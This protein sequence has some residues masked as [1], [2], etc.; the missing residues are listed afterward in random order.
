[1]DLAPGPARLTSLL[2]NDV[3]ARLE[4]LRIRGTRRFTNPTH[5]ETLAGRTGSSTEF[6]DYRDYVEGDDVRFI[7]W[8]AFARLR[9]PYLKLYRREEDV[10][11]AVLVDASA[12]MAFEG[13]LDLAKSLAA[14][15]GVLGCLNV[16]RVA[17]YAVNRA[18]E[19]PRRLPPCTGRASLR[20]LFSF[21]EGIEAGGDAPVEAAI[22]SLLKH[23]AGR[24]FAVVLS[25]FLTFGDL[26]KASN[27][28]YASG[29]EILAIQILGPSETDPDLSGDL[30]LVDA[31]TGRTLDVTSAA[32][33]LAIYQE[34]RAAFE[35]HLEDLCRQRAGRFLSVRSTDPPGEILF[36]RLRRKGWIE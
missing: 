30:R 4:R 1:M 22:E 3:I 18:G 36:D 23:H 32:D 16:E 26:R 35:R 10:H 5:G 28:L 25:D 13:K 11:V 29:L 24:G 33:L 20:T 9:R 14:A 12:S 7:D 21:L 31:E 15:F 19:G 6:K 8:N 27:A 17:A 34:H 2:A